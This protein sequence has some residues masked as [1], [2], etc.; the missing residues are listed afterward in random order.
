ML[1]LLAT[2]AA[3]WVS[4]RIIPGITHSGSALA[5]V[6]VAAVFGVVNALIAPVVR[7]FSFPFIV[8]TLGVFAL[9]INAA[10]LLLTSWTASL[11]GLGFHVDGFF[12]ALIGSL[13]ISAVSALLMLVFNN[14]GRRNRVPRVQG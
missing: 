2:A 1:R 13:V 3:F 5:L 8:L 11:L 9:V 4:A 12:A 10:M 14:E 6:G 7:L